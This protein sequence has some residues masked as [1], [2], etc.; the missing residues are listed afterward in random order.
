MGK[1][2]YKTKKCIHCG[3]NINVKYRICPICGGHV[4]EQL[5]SFPPVCPR[6]NK[7]LKIIVKD[8]EEYDLCSK[9]GGLWLD[10]GKFHRAT[11]ES[12]IY[13]KENF[14]KEYMRQPLKKNP[15]GY[16]PCVRCG[17]LMNRK[18]FG[19]ISGVM[20]DKCGRH[21]VWLDADELEKIRHF[22]ADGGLEKAQDREIEKNRGKIE[23]LASTVADVAFT[24]RLIHFWNPKRW[25]FRGF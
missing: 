20:I 24:Q 3:K 1:I 9:C 10:R 14:K 16:I 7:P 19:R 22:I 8:S 13:R 5:K 12:D 6:C 25:L 2:K 18:I 23:K 4:S 21:G 11:R 15:G 17:K